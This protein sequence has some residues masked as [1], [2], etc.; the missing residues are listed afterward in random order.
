MYLIVLLHHFSVMNGLTVSGGSVAFRSTT[1][2]SLLSCARAC[3]A[4]WSGCFTVGVHYTA[5]GDIT[6]ELYREHRDNIAVVEHSS[7]KI[8]W[9]GIDIEDK[10]P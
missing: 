2:S 8:I 6:C 9:R 1:E 4:E 10:T 7:A 5:N 3:A